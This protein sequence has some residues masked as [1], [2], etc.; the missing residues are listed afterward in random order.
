MTVPAAGRRRA[1]RHLR[2]AW[3]AC[4]EAAPGIWAGHLPVAVVAGLVPPATAWLTK[5][6]V[7]DLTGGRGDHA[8][9][10]AAGLGA[11]GLFGALLPHL[12][13]YLRGELGRRLDRVL[14]DRL[15]T[16]VNGFHGLA[17]FE[18]PQHLD[19]L[20]MAAQASGGSLSPVTGGMAE[21]GRNVVALLSL[22]ATL[23]VLSPVMAVVV[24]L[25]AVPVLLGRLALSRRRVGM[26]AATSAAMRKE[27]FYSAL[28]TEEQAAKEVRLY[29]LGGFFKDR[30]LG[31]LS[32]I[33]GAERRLDRKEAA[34]QGALG[35]LSA[36]VAGGG[37]VWAVDAALAGR[38][39]AGDV[40]AFVAAVAGV[41]AALVGLVAGL[42]QAHEA[43]LLFAYHVEVTELPDDL[44]ALPPAAREPGA[45]PALRHGIELRDVW[46]RYH[47]DHPWVLKGVDLF[48][49]FGRS[50][51]LVGLNGAGKSTL[52]KLLCRFYD[53]VRG[54]VRWDGADLRDIDPGEL[55]RRMG[56]L[57]Q[58]FMNY[59]LTA[60]ENIGVGDLDR[61]DDHDRV[62][63][64]AEL[65]G[66]HE[67][68]AALPQGYDTL[69]SRIFF[70]DGETEDDD[71]TAGTVLSGGQWQRLAL[72]R[73]LV[74]QNRDLLILDEPSAGLDARA[75]YEVHAGLR[76][77]RAGRTSLLVSHRLSAVREADAI[78]VLDGGRIT[79][80]GT[81]DELMAAGGVYERLFTVQAEGYV[82]QPDGA[83]VEGVPAAVASGT[84]RNSIDS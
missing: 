82:D 45:L 32:T 3:A 2:T 83:P 26:L 23:F 30:M 11:V 75:E 7:D 42:A 39:T 14:R 84:R 41:Q 35:A 58:D 13:E 15:H 65:A 44:T 9:G 57:F 40:T 74:R 70:A 79:E 81:H 71:P 4:W 27:L 22:L 55:R 63:G 29:G 34:V 60:R 6:L 43:L 21:T 73:A 80:R 24:L 37:L 47:D 77:H 62:R 19:R 48:I 28:M 59:D 46:F 1:L 17:R 16:A 8:L 33:Q 53:P 18:D 52:I 31:E 69:L 5:L 36:A 78:V 64:A 67:L 51:A 56:V 54:S 12:G 38:L 76:A 50:V 72:A 61:L 25:A 68:V 20:R 10:Y 66:A 49:P